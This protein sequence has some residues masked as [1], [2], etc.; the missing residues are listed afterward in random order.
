[1]RLRCKQRSLH[2]SWLYLCKANIS[3]TISTRKLTDKYE[4]TPA[5]IQQL[6]LTQN[7]HHNYRWQS[8]NESQKCNVVTHFANF[9]LM[10]FDILCMTILPHS[11][12]ILPRTIHFHVF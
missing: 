9:V 1:M 8:I 7:L 5:I 6:T 11:V 4:L 3:Q 12:T 10:C 2:K